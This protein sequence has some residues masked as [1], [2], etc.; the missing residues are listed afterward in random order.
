MGIP[1]SVCIILRNP[2]KSSLVHT[3]MLLATSI[4]RCASFFWVCWSRHLGPGF[5]NESVLHTQ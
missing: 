5:L 1:A 4:I 3:M 2:A